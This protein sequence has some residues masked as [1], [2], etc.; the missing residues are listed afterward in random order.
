MKHFPSGMKAIR[1]R[2]RAARAA[3]LAVLAAGCGGQY[4]SVR[5]NADAGRA[6]EA[7]VVLEAHRYYTTGSDTEPAAILA[8]R[9]DRPLRYGPWREVPMTPALLSHMVDLMRGT[10]ALG[11]DGHI[12]LD[13]KGVAIG[14]WYSYFGPPIVNLLE[15][16]GVEVSTP[17]T[18]DGDGPDA[19]RPG[20]R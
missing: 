14:A 9:E 10:R 5:F 18:A 12:V 7:G 6:L 2:S 15:D 20:A 4:G 1:L 11:P 17:F 13:A 19:F 16:G 8:L 3:V